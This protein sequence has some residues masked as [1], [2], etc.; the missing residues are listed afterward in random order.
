V[1]DPLN[2]DQPIRSVG[3]YQCNLC[4]HTEYWTNDGKDA[5]GARLD[6]HL[7]TEHGKD[8]S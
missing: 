8:L 2:P 1:T 6:Q 4:G 5:A 3:A 7:T